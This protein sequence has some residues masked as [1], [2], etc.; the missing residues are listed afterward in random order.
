MNISARA[1]RGA[2]RAARITRN[3]MHVGCSL[4]I[5]ACGYDAWNNWATLLLKTEGTRTM[6]TVVGKFDREREALYSSVPITFVKLS[7]RDGSITR[8]VEVELPRGIAEC[9]ETGQRVE[10]FYDKLHPLRV[11][12]PWAFVIQDKLSR[13]I[14]GIGAF[15]S[16]W[17]AVMVLTSGKKLRRQNN[18]R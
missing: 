16:L 10:I 13:D 7:Y 6:A 9:L 1:D 4:L 18:N 3:T 14:M 17:I 15:G 12:H 11:L 2:A 8:D 5:A